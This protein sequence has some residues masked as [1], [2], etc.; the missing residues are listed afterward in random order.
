MWLESRL[1]PQRWGDAVTQTRTILFW[2]S[3]GVVAGSKAEKI[4]RKIGAKI[5]LFFF[6]GGGSDLKVSQT[7]ESIFFE[8]KDQQSDCIIC[9]AME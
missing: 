2:L 8:L 3:G 9:N 1:K 6:R 4:Q 5:D 7:E